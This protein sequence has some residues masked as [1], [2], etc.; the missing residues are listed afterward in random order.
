MAKIEKNK[1][2]F[3]VTKGEKTRLKAKLTLGKST[4]S[5]IEEWRNRRAL[6][7]QKPQYIASEK[8]EN[9]RRARVQCLG[10]TLLKTLQPWKKQE[11][12]SRR[13]TSTVFFNTEEL[14]QVDQSSRDRR[15]TS[16]SQGI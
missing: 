3:L 13:G 6:M 8:K 4:Q 5:S 2:R 12:S 10:G 7:V 11:P 14:D 1:V 9:A 15:E 16:L